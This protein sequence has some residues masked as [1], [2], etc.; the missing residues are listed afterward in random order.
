MATHSSILARRILWTEDLVGYSSWG[1][2]ELNLT[3]QLSRSSHNNK[4]CG[5]CFW[6]SA[7]EIL[8]QVAVLLN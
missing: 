8:L 2:R 6:V 3:E 7:S 4:L 1:H 5:K